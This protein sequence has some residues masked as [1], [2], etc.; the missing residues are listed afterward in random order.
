[1]RILHGISLTTAT[2]LI[3]Y[4]LGFLNQSLL[5]RLLPEEQWGDLGVWST[6]IMFGALL[7]GEWISRG[8]TYLVGR[9]QKEAACASNALAYCGLLVLVLGA[10]AAWRYGTAAGSTVPLTWLLVAA[11]I[12]ANTAQKAGLGL[13]LGQDRIRRYAV[14]PL[15]LVGTYL[16]GN[17]LGAFAWRMDLTRVLLIW[18]G[19]MGFSALVGLAPSMRRSFRPGAVDPL[20]MH[21]TLAIGGRGAVSCVMIFLLFRSNFWLLRYFM[22]SESVATFKAATI[23]TDMMQRLPNAAG[24]VLLAKVVRGADNWQT[25]SLPVAQGVLV[26]SSA[27]ALAL[28]LF[29]PILIKVFFPLYP[30]AY[31]TLLWML[32]GLVFAG[33]GSVLNTKLAGQ[34]YPAVT[35]WA[36]MLAATVSVVLSTLLIPAMGVNGAALATSASLVLWG[37]IVST[38]YFRRTGLRWLDLL[39]LSEL[40]TSIVRLRPRPFRKSKDS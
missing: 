34:G 27:S 31:H 17:I 26:F 1:M 12:V 5:A 19:A 8:S 10:F 24:V 2:T 13:L 38:A 36:P 15:L 32:P 23:F 3:V 6:T 18:L 7:L 40:T 29:G 28:L 33:F 9:E 11:L 39:R 30:E 14:V 25:L 16:G 22:G 37:G 20:L 35:V 21:R 4:V